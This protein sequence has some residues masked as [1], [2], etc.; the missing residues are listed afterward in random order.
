MTNIHFGGETAEFIDLEI[1]GLAYPDATD[2]SD[3][4]WLLA[5]VCL[6]TGGFQGDISITLRCEDFVSFHRQLNRLNQTLRGKASLGT[7]ERSISLELTGNGRGDIALRGE[8]TDRICDGNR[9]EFFLD[10]DQSYLAAP[11]RHLVKV[12]QEY[13]PRGLDF[14]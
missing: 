5:R 2:P 7:L 11:L 12:T 13:P 6:A 1:S 8:V 9:L 3:A 4:N 10:F 14:Q